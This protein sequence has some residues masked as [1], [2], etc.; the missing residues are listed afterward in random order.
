MRAGNGATAAPALVGAFAQNGRRATQK[1]SCAWPFAGAP[2][3]G[4]DG[5][6]LL[7]VVG[8]LT[9]AVLDGRVQLRVESTQRVRQEA[10]LLLAL[11]RGEA[12][13]KGPDGR[14]RALRSGEVLVASSVDALDIRGESGVRLIGMTLPAHLLVPR[15]VA[16]ERLR[17]GLLKAHGG[18]VAGLLCELLIGLMSPGRAIPGAGALTDAVGG[19]ISATLEDCWAGEDSDAGERLGRARMESIGQYLRRHFADPELSPGDVAQAIGVSRRYLHKLYANENRSFRQELI[20][21]RIEACLKAFADT[22]QAGKTIADIAFA[23]GYTD[24]SQFNRHFRRLKNA[25]PTS[26][27]QALLTSPLKGRKCARGTPEIELA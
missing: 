3:L 7:S 26:V 14:L 12:A 25:T 9:L 19:L 16:R 1:A 24:I 17:G 6:L 18:G 13:F 21:L 4:P 23:S 2:N 10:V 22:R 5:Q 27:R 20:G 11:A 15:F 8:D